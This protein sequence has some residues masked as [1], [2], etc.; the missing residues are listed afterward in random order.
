MALSK[1]QN[2]NRKYPGAKSPRPDNYKFRKDEANERLVAWQALTPK[3]QLAVLDTRP[4]A[5]KRQRARILAAMERG[6][7]A[8]AVP[9]QN[10]GVV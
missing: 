9:Q 8:P 4:G 2:N 7:N 1:R 6:N 5:S 3:Q 10:K